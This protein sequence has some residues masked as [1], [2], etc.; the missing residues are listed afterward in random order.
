MRC[1]FSHNKT[2]EVL[3]TF[4]VTLLCKQENL[5]SEYLLSTLETN[6][7]HF[8]FVCQRLKK[9]RCASNFRYVR[10]SVKHV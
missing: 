1:A 2:A 10:A 8:V 6:F 3:C 9:N 5:E 4:T 7:F